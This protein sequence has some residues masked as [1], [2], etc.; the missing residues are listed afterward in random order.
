MIAASVRE[1][2][3]S[4][5][6]RVKDGRASRVPATVLLR[7]VREAGYEGGIGQLNVFVVQH[8]AVGPEP[9]VRFET[10]RDRQM[11]ADFTTIRRGRPPL[12]AL[13]ATLGYN[14]AT[15]VRFTSDEDP[16]TLCECLPEAFNY[17]GGTP[18]HVL[19]D[20]AKSVIITRDA[21]GEGQH[22]WNTEMLK[23]AEAY[24]FTPRVCKPY[25]AQTKGKV[26]RFNRY[27]KQSFVVPLA[28]TLKQS[29]P[30]LDVEVANRR[31]IVP[32]E[33]CARRV[34]LRVPSEKT[35]VQIPF[36]SSRTCC[37]CSPT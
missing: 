5:K 27:L 16:S 19:F 4:K 22:R 14:C 21:Y 25:R 34:H 18:E 10:P 2:L 30:K 32:T 7:E 3:F 8:N 33:G 35:S 31:R 17:L 15:C 28:A 26:E 13:V 12:L 24:G 6:R 37:H 29:A 11:Q 1:T 20:N 9:V 36:Y 23:L